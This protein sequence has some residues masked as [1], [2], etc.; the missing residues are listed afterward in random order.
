MRN[1]ILYLY[2][3]HHFEETVRFDLAAEL[4]KGEHS[5]DIPSLFSVKPHVAYVYDRE[6]TIPSSEELFKVIESR[7]KDDSAL[8]VEYFGP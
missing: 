2:N 3:F 5:Y 7:G 8:L 1:G 6:R 4:K